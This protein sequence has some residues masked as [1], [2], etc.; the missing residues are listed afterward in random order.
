[1]NVV[2]ENLAVSRHARSHLGWWNLY[3]IAKFVLFFQGLID[4]HGLA[5]LSFLL[6]L[7]LP[8][9]KPWRTIRTVLA[10]PVALLLLHHDS[11]LPPI[12]RLFESADLIQAFSF[13]YMIELA[14]RVVSLELLMVAVVMIVGYYYL[15]V[16]IR[17]GS[18]SAIGIIAIWL[19]ALWPQSA[20]QQPMAVHTTARSHEIVS[21]VAQ[22]PD[23]QL[24][25]FYAQQGQIRS[26]FPPALQGQPFDILLLNVC[27]LSW[28]DL[29]TVHLTKHPLFAEFDILFKQ[30][31]SATSYSGPAAVRVLRASCGQTSHD[32]LY[33]PVPAQCYL[34]DNLRN[35]GFNE[36]F[37]MNHTG[38]FDD[39]INLVK[40]RG[41]VQANPMPQKGFSGYQ[42]SFDG[43]PIY[44]DAEV[45]KRWVNGLPA[46]RNVTFYNTVSLHDGNKLVSG[47]HGNSIDSYQTRARNLLDDLYAFIQAMKQAKRNIMIVMVPEHGAS[48]KS[49]KMQ[50]AGMRDIPSPAIVNVPVGIKFVG[51]NLKDGFHQEVNL[52]VSHAALSQLIANTLATNPFESGALEMNALLGNLPQAPLVAEN[53]GAVLMMYNNIPYIKLAGSD[54]IEYPK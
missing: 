30:F 6:L 45:L 35:L 41:N 4:F 32:K 11:Y 53:S 40:N 31:N 42:K 21:T 15:S 25:Q 10:V 28:D 1:M 22:T 17:F 20:E 2:S 3:F 47:N 12:S 27:S 49:D 18:V 51:P 19:H 39:F 33:E 54:W 5:N 14:G 9:A 26:Q 43:S 7:A 50:I 24:A 38:Q 34:F 52:P 29:E 48:L 44:R 37:V 46:G 16:W 13:S 36:H 23:Q 8:L